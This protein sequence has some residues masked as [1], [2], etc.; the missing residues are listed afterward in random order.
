MACSS[1]DVFGTVV[2]SPGLSMELVL[3]KASFD[4]LTYLGI[5]SICAGAAILF[6]SIKMK[7]F[8]FGGESSILLALLAAGNFGVARLEG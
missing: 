5:L 2:A 4:C 3:K 1:L 6:S 7:L 8:C